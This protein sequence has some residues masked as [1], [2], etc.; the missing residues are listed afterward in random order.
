MKYT[1][2]E[3]R[4]AGLVFIAWLLPLPL[5]AQ[6]ELAAVVDHD[7]DRV[8]VAARAQVAALMT[9]HYEPGEFAGWISPP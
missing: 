1:G 5:L 2:T 6:D 9:P 8:E 7:R 3:S 4:K